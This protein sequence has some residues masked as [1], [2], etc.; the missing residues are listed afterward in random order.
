LTG[1]DLNDTY[2][3]AISNAATPNVT[4]TCGGTVTAVAG[5]TSVALT[6]G[7][8]AGGASCTVTVDVTSLTLGGHLNTSGVVSSA[9]AADSTT[10]FD[11]LN[12]TPTAAPGLSKGFTT[13]IIA[14]GTSTMTLTIDNSA[15]G[16]A[17][18]ALALLDTYP[19]A[20]SNA[21]TPN[22]TNTCGGTVTALAGSGS[23]DLS[24][25]TVAAGGSCTVTV[26]VT[27]LTAGGHL[28]TTGVVSSTEA[29][30]S[31]VAMDTLMVTTPGGGGG[32]VTFE[33]LQTG[34]SSSSATVATSGSV[35]AVNGDLYLAAISSKSFKTVTSVSGLGLTWTQVDT[36]CS[37]RNAT[38]VNVWKAQG[39][40]SG[41][42]PVTATLSGAP[43]NAAI[44]VSRYSGANQTNPIG[45]IVSGN[46]NGVDG[47]CSGGIDGN[48]Y[49]LNL[50]TT[51][52]GSVVVGAI[53]MRNRSHTPGA[54]YTEQVEFIQGSGGSSA[55][56][57][58]MDRTVASPS[59]VTVGGAF[60]GSVDYAVIGVEIKP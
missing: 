43:S 54:G 8:V 13:P 21:T 37:G 36:Q 16:V 29:P 12:V 10:A 5:G 59:S 11:T 34:G 33:E 56:V 1:V 57:A 15:N 47:A 55:S 27:S 9:E 23:V 44:A 3:V 17:L 28:N 52:S 42:G 31:A 14:G 51:V 4:N 58:V 53:A 40:P 35:T 38:G 6:G 26:D 46:S 7:T 32:N 60:S 39:I 48:A 41:S 25:G 20:I 2:P 19:V 49:S 24:G 22:V 18:T 50:S 45:N 30:D